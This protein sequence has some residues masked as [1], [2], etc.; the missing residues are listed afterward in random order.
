VSNYLHTT[1]FTRGKLPHWEVQGGRYF[2]TVRCAD[3]LPR[4]AMERLR[5][6]IS[7]LHSIESRSEEFAELQRFYFRTLE[8]YLDAGVGE[9]RLQHAC[10]A[11]RV[12]AEF[13][14]LREW[15]VN[16]PHYVVMPNHWH[17]MIEP[18]QS[19][20]RSL[21]EIIRRLKGRSARTI[22]KAL[23]QAGALWQREWF[24]RWMRSDQEYERC[25]RYIQNNPV[26]AGLPRQ[27]C[28]TK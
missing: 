21:A 28:W 9:C 6:V 16:V 18:R 11:E 12:I 4:E 7:Q 5:E 2:V 1:R 26:K 8:K 14:N 22:N 13:D 27:D 20:T 10:A 23:G 24:D 25:V 17:A 19:C 15:Q 3:S